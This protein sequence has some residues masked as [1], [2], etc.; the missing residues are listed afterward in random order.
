MLSLVKNTILCEI[1]MNYKI[2]N[3]FYFKVR[4]GSFP[5]FRACRFH[6]ITLVAKTSGLKIW[7][8]VNEFLIILY[9]YRILIAHLFVPLYW[10]YLN[11][12]FNPLY[13]SLVI[14][15]CFILNPYW[16]LCLCNKHS[17]LC[18]V[19]HI[20]THIWLLLYLYFCVSHESTFVH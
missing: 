8:G 4:N 1:F 16:F 13:L 2:D 3:Q 5:G 10:S 17:A 12:C 9:V 6:T 15:A 7:R 11:A 18:N 19:T 20:F 14:T